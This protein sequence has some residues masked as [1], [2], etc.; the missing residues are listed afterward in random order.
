MKLLSNTDVPLNAPAVNEVTHDITCNCNNAQ[1]TQ[2]NSYLFTPCKVCSNLQPMPKPSVLMP[3]NVQIHR[4]VLIINT[5]ISKEKKLL[6]INYC[7]N[8]T[9]KFPKVMIY[10]RLTSSKFT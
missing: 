4:K 6:Y 9:L 10:V 8:T 7:R 5:K 1:Q 2:P 3:S